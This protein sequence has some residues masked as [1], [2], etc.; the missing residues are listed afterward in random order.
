MLT[1]TDPAAVDP[2]TRFDALFERLYPGLFG[3]TYRVL[4]DRLE[5]EDTLQDAFLR[6]A[7]APVLDRPDDEV[8]AW[9]RR[10]CLNLS[11]NRRRDAYR[12]RERLERAG[13]LTLTDDAGARDEPAGAAERRET[14]A[15]VRRALASLP[16]RQRDCILLRHSGYSYTEIAATLGVALGSVGVLLARAEHA[17]RAAYEGAS[18]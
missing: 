5:A 11:A 9:L 13:R 1:S 4:G 12:A 8:A 6:L 16:E 10:V 7:D 18:R 15:E 14:E 2:A 17:F 3:L